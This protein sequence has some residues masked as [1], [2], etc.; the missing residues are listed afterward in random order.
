[1]IEYF[2][3]KVLG[4]NKNYI[5]LDLKGIGI[6]IFCTNP[7]FYKEGSN[8]RVPIYIHI[9]E[10]DRDCYGFNDFKEK[11]LFTKLLTVRGIGPK[12][13]FN[14]IGSAGKDSI[15]E[16]IA[17]KDIDYLKKI[18][19]LGIKNASEIV[20]ELSDKFKKYKIENNSVF[21]QIFFALEKMEFKTKDINYAISLLDKNITDVQ[22]GVKECLKVLKP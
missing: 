18:N 7:L 5:I 1:M 15:I 10:N 13:A 8:Y 19:G 20:L 16:A 9:N 14:I 22:V 6:K 2:E 17:N 3:G 21:K 4:S 12:T 11:D